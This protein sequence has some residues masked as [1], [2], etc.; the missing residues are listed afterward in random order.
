MDVPKCAISLKLYI[1]LKYVVKMKNAHSV[2]C[3]FSSVHQH[4]I[5]LILDVK[6][7]LGKTQ[8]Q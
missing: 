4:Q 8:E 7:M 6:L 5:V 2:K 1:I 3:W